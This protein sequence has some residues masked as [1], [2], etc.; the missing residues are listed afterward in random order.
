MWKYTAMWLWR[1]AVRSRI[2]RMVEHRQC[3]SL[4]TCQSSTVSSSVIAELS[5]V[6]TCPSSQHLDQTP[7]TTMIKVYVTLCLYSLAR[8]HQRVDFSTKR[9][10]SCLRIRD[11][12]N[13]IT[14]AIIRRIMS[15][16]QLKH[17]AIVGSENLKSYT[18]SRRRERS[19]PVIQK[20]EKA[21]PSRQIR[22]THVLS[23]SVKHIGL[24]G[25]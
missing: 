20:R 14:L 2:S 22:D 1:C 25:Y 9:L 16:R 12:W 18:T 24:T 7:T 11:V 3:W 17:M 19:N 5:F 10:V 8:Q 4:P 21:N 13:H 23:K 6:E 15:A